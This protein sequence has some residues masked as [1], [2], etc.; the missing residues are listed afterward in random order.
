VTRTTPSRDPL[1][2]VTRLLVDGTNLLHALARRAGGRDGDRQ[3]P[4]ALVGRL[5]AAIPP[6]T[7]IE[8]VFDGPAERGLRNERIAHG[9]SVRYGGRHTADAILI[10]LVEDVAVAGGARPGGRSPST[11]ALLVVSDDRDLRAAVGRRGARTAG[12]LWLLRRME[13]PRLMSP[14]A[15]NARPPAPPRVAQPAPGETG[16]PGE[17]RDE[18]DRPGWSPGRH[19]TRKRGPSKRPSKPRPA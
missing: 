12:A 14:S 18:D 9:V 3:P 6:E 19:A 8:L 7:A 10:T 4:A 17:T 16:E 1:T 2:G 15:G 13:R 11:D 5:R